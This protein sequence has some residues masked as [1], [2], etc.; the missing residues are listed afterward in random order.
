MIGSYLHASSA[1][2]VGRMGALVGLQVMRNRERR[3]TLRCTSSLA[4]D[5]A[6]CIDSHMHEIRCAADLRL[7]GMQTGNGADLAAADARSAVEEL[8]NKLAMH[9]VAMRPPY[10]SRESGGYATRR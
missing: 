8:A 6:T 5:A 10:L 4:L 7:A 3:L 1:P 2:G 9:V